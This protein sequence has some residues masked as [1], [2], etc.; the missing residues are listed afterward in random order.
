M[1]RRPSAKPTQSE[2]AL[3]RAVVDYL[4]RALPKEAVLHHSPNEGLHKPQYR[5]KQLA[6]GMR[7]GWPDIQILYQGRLIC[8]E[9]KTKT[10]GLSEKQTACHR[11]IVLAGGV[12][13]VARSVEEVEEFLSQLMPLKAVVAA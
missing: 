6:K 12:V 7:A 3:H 8:I 2:D 9:L 11:E 10:G 1:K 4:G 5:A 13:T